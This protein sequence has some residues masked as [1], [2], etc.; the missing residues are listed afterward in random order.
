MLN[1]KPINT[2]GES[3]GRNGG[4][5]EGAGRKPGGYVKPKEAV[6]YD[7]AK[8]RSET[9]KA[10]KA[11]FEY[12]ILTGEYVARGAV[13]EA[14]AVSYAALAQ[15]MRTIGDELERKGVPIDV[16]TKVE[17]IIDAAMKDHA[18]QMELM[19]GRPEGAEQ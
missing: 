6:D 5:R 2:F 10:D 17:E 13:R 11:E 9:A 18:E 12:K 15:T 14:A 7:I 16:C 4:A 1:D 8:A 3:R 19:A